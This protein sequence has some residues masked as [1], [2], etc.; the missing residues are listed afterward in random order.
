MCGSGELLAREGDSEER[1]ISLA[2]GGI[3]DSLGLRVEFFVDR[4]DSIARARGTELPIAIEDSVGEDD[5]PHRRQ[6]GGIHTATG[7]GVSGMHKC[8]VTHLSTAVV[9]A[10]V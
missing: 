6:R 7:P 5:S 8:F 1:M 3:E 2:G 9:V 10:I 4:L